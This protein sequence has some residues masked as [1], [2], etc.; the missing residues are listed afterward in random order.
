MTINTPDWRHGIVLAMLLASIVLLMPARADA[1]GTAPDGFFGVNPGDLFKQPQSQ[2][3]THLSA[4][5]DDG[6]QVVRMGAWWSDLEPAPPVNGQHRYSWSDIDKQVEALA[7][8]NLQWEPLLCFSATWGSKIDGDYSG[9]PEGT[10]NFARFGAALAQR[11]GRNGSFWTEH[12][13]LPSLPVTSYEIW[14]EENANVYWHPGTADSY[15]DL[16]AATRSAIHGVDGSARV[17][18]GGL[19]AADNSSV[20]GAADFVRQMY[21]HRPDLRGSVDA[22]ALHPYG[23]RPQDV[24]ANVARFRHDLD[25]IA[26]PGVPIELTE[27]GWT[28]TDISES[29]RAAYL[30]EVASTLSRTDCGIDR[31]TAYAWLGPEQAAGDREQWFG[32]ANRDGSNKPSASAY[33]SSVKLMRGLSGAAPTDVVRLCSGSGPAAIARAVPAHLRLNVSVRRDPRRA[34]RVR[35]HAR[36][37]SGCRLRVELRAQP[38]GGVARASRVGMVATRRAGRNRT[39]SVSVARRINGTRTVRIK[40]TAI[41]SNGLSVTRWRTLRLRA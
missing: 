18:V 8:H 12:P 9:A 31:L 10:D 7:R 26:G 1:A 39:L 22:V 11:Y 38:A 19:A 23:R 14:N 20:Q 25:H 21:A 6:V 37:S 13:E 35:V 41:G 3:D 28:T 40:V 4:I 33:A 30:R 29:T 16:Y 32:I 34:G 17:V 15:A 2:W 36:C 24:Y 5:A 27:L